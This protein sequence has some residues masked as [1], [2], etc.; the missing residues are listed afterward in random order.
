LTIVLA[1]LLSVTLQTRFLQIANANPQTI[2]IRSDGSIYPPTA[3]ITTV[4]NVTYTFTDNIND[5][6]MMERDDIVI[7]GD[8]FTLQGSRELFSVGINLSGRENVTVRNT[9]IKDFYYGIRLCSSSNYN[10]IIKNKLIGN[11]ISIYLD[12]SSNNSISENDMESD[13]YGVSLEFSSNNKVYGNNVTD[14]NPAGIIIDHFSNNNNVYENNMT[15]NY[16]GIELGYSSGNS[17]S[18][19]NVANN[20]CGIYLYSS[21]GNNASKNSVVNN[22]Y[23]IYIHEFSTDSNVYENNVNNNTYGIWL[24]NASLNRIYHN[25]FVENSQQ[26]SVDP[27]NNALYANIWDDGYPSGGNYWSNYTGIDAN[28]DGIGDSN[29][30]IDTNNNDRY[31]LMGMFYGFNVSWIDSGYDVELISNSSVSVFGVGF[32]IEHPEDLNTRTIKFNVTGETG[33]VGFCR[34]CIPTALLNATYTVLLNG[35]EIPFT[36]L[37]CSNNTHSYLYFNYTHSTEEVIIIP[38]FPTF[39]ALPL[40]FMIAT[41]AALLKKRKH[42]PF[43]FY[44]SYSFNLALTSV[45]GILKRGRIT[46]RCEKTS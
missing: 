35:T 39:I 5:S 45:S 38:E 13:T 21:S 10:T 26:V 15:S 9:Q 18:R 27:S 7:D 28:V 33:T 23:G 29:C 19:N 46:K 24:M 20:Y 1:I 17:I 42:K 12:S 3:S 11:G 36:L 14:S 16:G 32:W 2:Y 8:D 40:F 44:H 25:N 30:T 34:I 37:P 41:L 43:F 4:D 31:P 6:I 22:T